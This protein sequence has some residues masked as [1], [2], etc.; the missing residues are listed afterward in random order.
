MSDNN[1]ITAA[2]TQDDDATVVVVVV[3][4]ARQ[5]KQ[6]YLMSAIV[7][8]GYDTTAFADYMGQQRGK[9]K[10]RSNFDRKR[11]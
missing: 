3:E 10:L 9:P 1:N 7:Q 4:L 5:E 11:H 6:Q 8:T 2:F